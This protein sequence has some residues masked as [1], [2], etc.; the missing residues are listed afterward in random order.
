MSSDA[1][2][3]SLY[4]FFNPI[5]PAGANAVEVMLDILRCER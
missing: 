4:R 1:A 2:D 3:E 5:K